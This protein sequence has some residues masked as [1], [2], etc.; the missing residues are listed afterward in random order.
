MPALLLLCVP[1][2]VL[3]G[4]RENNQY[5]YVL[6]TQKNQNFPASATE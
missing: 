1:K 4:Q 6:L 2:E 5:F 3:R